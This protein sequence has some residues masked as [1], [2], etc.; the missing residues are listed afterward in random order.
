MK[1]QSKILYRQA[2]HLRIN[3]VSFLKKGETHRFHSLKKIVYWG[4]FGKNKMVKI[5]AE[6]YL[7]LLIVT[8]VLTKQCGFYK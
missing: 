8:L 4:N 1:S 2:C 3:E 6:F 5:K 7:H